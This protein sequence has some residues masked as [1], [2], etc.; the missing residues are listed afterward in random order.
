MQINVNLAQN[1]NGPLVPRAG[2]DILAG[3]GA[4][5]TKK[6]DPLLMSRVMSVSHGIRYFFTTP[7]K[8]FHFREFLSIFIFRLNIRK[9]FRKK[10]YAIQQHL[11]ALH[12]TF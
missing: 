8:K 4:K 2:G 5:F 7:K 12:H 3:D 11:L 10:W 1:L 6:R 9:F